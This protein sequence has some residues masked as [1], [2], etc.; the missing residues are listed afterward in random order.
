MVGFAEKERLLKKYWKISERQTE[1]SVVLA[2]SKWWRIAGLI[3]CAA[4]KHFWAIE[5]NSWRRARRS[6]CG[7]DARPGW[8]EF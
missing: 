6:G 5:G 8:R 3:R 2:D 7:G 1:T 4:G